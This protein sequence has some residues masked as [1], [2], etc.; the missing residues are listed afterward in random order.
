M[1]D[2]YL[3]DTHC[4]LWWNAEPDRLHPK[5]Y[6]AIADGNNTIL[7]SVASAWEISIKYALGKLKLPDAP[8]SY[9]PKRLESNSI[10]ALPIALHHALAV[11]SLPILHRDPF[12][13]LLVAQ[14]QIEDLI[15]I[16]ADAK[17][18]QYEISVLSA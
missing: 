6:D 2:R 4:W 7:L 5:A 1:V 16:T 13:R 10:T 15:L 12:D 3:I 9:V 17:I 18:K 14:A 11:S 8:E